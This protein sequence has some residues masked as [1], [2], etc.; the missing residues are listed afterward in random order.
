MRSH[1]RVVIIGGGV[2][3]CSLLYHLAKLGW[4]DTVLVEKNELTSGSTW[5]AAGL[6]THFAHNLTIMH[7]RAHSVHL[8]KSVLAQESG[9]PVSFH[10]CGA[11]RVTASP[12]R[13]DEFRQVQGL[14]RFAGFDFHMLDPQ[15][16]QEIYPLVQTQGLLGAIYEPL[17]GHV[18]PS[19]ATQALAKCARALGATISRHNRVH[20]IDKTKSDEWCVRTEQGDIVAELVVNAAGTWCREV[21]A[22][23]G[24]DLP[25]VP[26]LH[27]YL[28]M[29]RIDAL[30]ELDRE[31][32]IIRDPEESWYV[33]QERDGVIIGPYEKNGQ[34]WSVDAV[35]QDFAMELLPPALDRVQDIAARAMARIPAIADAGLKTII[36]GPITFT[37]DANPLI[38]PAFSLPNA[39]LLT[40]S[41]MGVMEG[42]GAGKFL[43]EWMV[44]GEPPMDPLPV[45]P[46]RFGAY[47]DR[48][49]RVAKA[50]ECFGLQFGIHY[51][52]EERPAGRPR[53]IS[54]VYPRLKESGAVFGSAYGW[55]RPNWFSS[56]VNDSST[57]SFRQCNWFDAVR[58]ECE[59]VRDNV[60]VADLSA[61]SKYEVG[62]GD[63]FDFLDQIGANRAPRRDGAISLMHCLHPSGGIE[64]EFTVTRLAGDD[65]YLNS[66]AAAERR[67]WDLLQQRAQGYPNLT[68][69]NVTAR[70]GV[71]GV[72]GPES[73]SLLHECCDVD[74]GFNAFPWLTAR[75]IEIAG[76]P[77]RALRV[78]Y[79][80]ELG[81]ELH[82]A[83]DR[84]LELFTALMAHRRKYEIGFYGAFAM[85]S[86][87]LEKG[88]RAW[89]VDLTTERTPLES[90]LKSFVKT[91][92]REFIGRDSL[93]RRAQ[94]PERWSMALL[95][96]EEAG[97]D[98][99]YGH[100]VFDQNE[101]IGIVTSGGY[102]HSVNK[103][104]ALAF[105]RKLPCNPHDLRVLVL[106]QPVAAHVLD[107]PPYDP[108]NARLRM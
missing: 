75:Q 72:M 3:G 96:L 62:G 24:L 92:N 61:F 66:A 35:P 65:F 48:D 20:R 12:D 57:L 31:L 82:V 98:P 49:Y 25:A 18:D 39:Y 2:M 68:I 26:M 60:A 7:M 59:S 40:G 13:M 9:Q 42:G 23:M 89:G 100:A 37:P 84:Q 71:L 99:F 90:G 47:A 70:L 53:R 34:P 101:P 46:R 63:A 73:R 76:I 8:Y 4:S 36:N 87:R 44:A 93:L 30:V 21:G 104:L 83:M 102:G 108:D 55:E 19:Q 51:P 81:W 79:V 77:V 54:A 41:S 10:P 88:Y 94:D 22:M 64:S 43:A 56:Q 105:F 5:H 80:G 32:P 29:D 38:G 78:S 6:C 58:R 95:E 103:V 1:A 11:L 97:C 52:F 27:Q 91:E 28:V 14:G 107:T 69:V 50:I 16:L 15:Q 67:D 74:F 45:D 86:L 106:D 85:N 33:R 17:D